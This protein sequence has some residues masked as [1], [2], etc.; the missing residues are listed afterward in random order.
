MYHPEKTGADLSVIF[1]VQYFDSSL[2]MK[3]SKSKFSFYVSFYFEV[4]SLTI[5]SPIRIICVEYFCALLQISERS[6]ADFN[7]VKLNC[8][9]ISLMNFT[10]IK[11]FPISALISIT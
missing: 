10:P 5:I 8:L 11:P 9:S 6:I 7:Q 2:L 3:P 4:F 1:Y